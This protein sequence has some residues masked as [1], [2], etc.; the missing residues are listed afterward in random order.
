MSQRLIIAI[1]ISGL[2]GIVLLILLNV[3]NAFQASP[4]SS[5]RVASGPTPTATLSASSS[6]PSPTP[7]APP[8]TAPPT[9]SSSPGAVPGAGES[10]GTMTLRIDPP[11]DFELSVATT[12]GWA[13]DQPLR[14]RDLSSINGPVLVV[15]GERLKVFV[16]PDEPE[17]AL[18]L[19]RTAADGTERADYAQTRA[20]GDAVTLTTA[21]DHAHGTATFHGL[22][23]NA[24]RV[25]VE[26]LPMKRAIFGQPLGNKADAR[27]INGSVDWT[28]EPA[29]AGYQPSPPEPTPV[30]QGDQMQVPTI[31]LSGAGRSRDGVAPC[32]QGTTAAG[33]VSK[34][35]CGF[36]W[37]APDD[38][39]GTLVVPRN[40]R[41]LLTA[42]SGWRIAA[43]SVRI[44][45]LADVEAT[46][47]DPKS[48]KVLFAGSKRNAPVPS[49]F[50]DAP[51]K[52]TWVIQADLTTDGTKKSTARATWFFL[53]RT[54]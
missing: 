34:P 48:K 36:F 18:A 26:R 21:G 16:R 33:T 53:I 29:P 51:A 23:T 24:S 41:L 47:G 45:T 17:A 37:P 49:L 1:G 3:L 32:P 38:Y 19:L 28:C 7:T 35:D 30:P 9:A 20:T 11:V 22:G 4:T 39:P 2:V 43:W 50:F 31:S 25:P 5:P 44:S 46:L 15:R 42:E 10:A 8:A 40:A 54:T 52:G 13:P 14:V 27:L 6:V 12:C